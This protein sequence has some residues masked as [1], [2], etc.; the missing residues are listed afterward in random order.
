V[1][2]NSYQE[3]KEVS[4]EYNKENVNPKSNRHLLERGWVES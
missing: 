1:F 2:S 4:D 3:L